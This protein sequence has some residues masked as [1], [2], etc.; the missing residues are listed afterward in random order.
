MRCNWSIFLGKKRKNI[1]LTNLK[2]DV[3]KCISTKCSYS[4][5]IMLNFEELE[6]R[7]IL[8]QNFAEIIV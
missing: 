6:T 7:R 8:I 5:T 4:H 3:N 2:T 1:V